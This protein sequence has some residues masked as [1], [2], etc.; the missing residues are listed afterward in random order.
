MGFEVEEKSLVE[1]IYVG[2]IYN[3]SK[4]VVE[5]RFSNKRILSKK[6]L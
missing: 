4:E 2:K 1:P 3:S 6:V 5:R